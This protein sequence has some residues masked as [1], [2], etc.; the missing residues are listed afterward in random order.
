MKLCSRADWIPGILTTRVRIAGERVS[1]KCQ[2]GSHNTVLRD[3]KTP[4]K[5]LIARCLD[6]HAVVEFV[7][8]DGKIVEVVRRLPK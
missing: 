4:E 7:K 2:C 6:C 8:R 5:K 1:I 3:E